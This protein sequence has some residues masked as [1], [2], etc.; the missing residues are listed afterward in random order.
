MMVLE[1]RSYDAT[2]DEPKTGWDAMNI[3]AA[4]AAGRELYVDQNGDIWTNSRREYVGKIRKELR[5]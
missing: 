4:L 5:R 1:L 3:Q 2:L